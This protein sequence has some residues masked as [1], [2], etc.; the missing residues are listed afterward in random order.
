MGNV[1]QYMG[2]PVDSISCYIE[3]LVINPQYPEV[4]ANLGTVYSTL[5]EWEQAF[6]YYQK[7]IDLNPEFVGAYRH[8][9]NAWRQL[10][11]PDGYAI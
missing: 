4:Y 7:A 10:N 11:Q 2:N 1:L 6:E 5:E 3:A 9:V 8:L